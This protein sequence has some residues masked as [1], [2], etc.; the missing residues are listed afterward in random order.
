MTDDEWLAWVHRIREDLRTMKQP[1]T[2]AE[3]QAFMEWHADYM[4][5]V[6]HLMVQ[7]LVDP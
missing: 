4:R 1:R 6:D 7:L 5:M 3:Y 2:W